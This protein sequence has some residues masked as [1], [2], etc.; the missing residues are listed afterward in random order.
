MTALVLCAVALCGISAWVP[1]PAWGDE[2]QSAW[3]ASGEENADANDD[4][5]EQEGGDA[6]DAD[7]DASQ[8]DGSDDASSSE[9]GD[10]NTS[11]STTSEDAVK[12]E[13]EL[14]DYSK[15]TLEELQDEVTK[16]TDNR[17]ATKTKSDELAAQIADVQEKLDEVLRKSEKAQRVAE[18]AVRERYKVQ[19][20][21]G[22]LFDALLCA[23]DFQSFLAGIEYIEEASEV[24]VTELTALRREAAE[25]ERTKAKLEAE[26][27]EIDKELAYLDAALEEAT[28]ARDEAQ[29][30]A[31][32]VANAHLKPD[33]ADW[34][35]S[36]ADFVEE[37]G[38]RID[39][40]LAGSPM[41]GQGE[42]FA[43]AAWK[44]HIDPRWSPAISNQE[45]SK[46]RICIRP[47]NAWGWGAADP[48][49]AGLALEWS[50]WEEAI[51][52]HVRGLAI[53]YG[54]TISPIGAQRYCPPGWE[55]WYANTVNEMNSI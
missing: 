31:D 44:N 8:S 47:Y 54:Y 29:R 7:A 18:R 50:S 28:K 21:Y 55:E 2:E 30:K 13:G 33:G 52:A 32:L 4:A 26:K 38:P 17:D 16:L 20:Q 19:R 24:S 15:M 27:A 45:S 40:Y 51:N 36:K 39:A 53:G 48:D 10:A 25:Y 9:G 14:P 34:D 22:T 46:G 35:G 1:T 41:E 12:Y 5:S 37:W 11:T 42:T 3:E 23:E 6:G 43:K 49:P